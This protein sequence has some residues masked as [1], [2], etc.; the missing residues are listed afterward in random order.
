VN[1]FIAVEFI[2]ESEAPGLKK[3]GV[4]TVVRPEIELIVTASE[5]P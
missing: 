5:I 4:L 3:G 2:N 1:L